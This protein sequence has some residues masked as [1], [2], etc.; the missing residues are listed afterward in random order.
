MLES[1]SKS[2]F[3][4]NN[5]FLILLGKDLFLYEFYSSNK[6]KTLFS[7]KILQVYTDESIVQS[8]IDH[9]HI[10]ISTNRRVLYIN[11]DK[12]L[13]FETIFTRDSIDD[14]GG[15]IADGRIYYIK[16]NFEVGIYNIIDKKKFSVKHKAQLSIFDLNF[17]YFLT[18]TQNYV[19]I[20]SK[21]CKELYFISLKTQKIFLKEAIIYD[22][23]S[24][25]ST[26][27]Y[28]I[29][30]S[31]NSFAF[32]LNFKI[33]ILFDGNKPLNEGLFLETLRN[34]VT[35][36]KKVHSYKLV[37]GKEHVI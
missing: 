25:L 33:G 11:L 26:Q 9:N 6:E 31:L 1:S 32:R 18:S 23:C 35:S 5:K 12:D 36:M 13:N 14:Y 15:T 10:L 37:R 8:V 3:S 34:S 29:I 21:F 28:F 27:D 19:V 20:M 7:N 17:S 4:F 2:L 30:V 16:S 22:K 24:F